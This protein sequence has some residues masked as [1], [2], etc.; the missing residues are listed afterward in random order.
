MEPK[1][2]ALG[3][4]YPVVWDGPQQQSTRGVTDPINDDA[5]TGISEL[6]ESLE[7]FID[8]ASRIIVNTNRSGACMDVRAHQY[9]ER[10]SQRA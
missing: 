7:V 1:T 6:S 10:N 8:P 2:C 9:Q 5:L 4:T 3:H